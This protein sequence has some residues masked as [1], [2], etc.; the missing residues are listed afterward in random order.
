MRGVPEGRNTV[1]HHGSG[2]KMRRPQRASP[3]RGDTRR[4]GTRDWP[5]TECATLE[6]YA[7]RSLC[8]PSGACLRW[9]SR[10][11]TTSVV[12]YDLPSLRDSWQRISV[13]PSAVT[14]LLAAA[15]GKR[16]RGGAGVAESWSDPSWRVLI[17][18]GHRKFF[19]CL[20]PADTRGQV[21]CAARVELP[22]MRQGDRAV[23]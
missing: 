8:R 9:S 23:R 1:A 2:G 16:C 7:R 15:C 6:S 21:H 14:C 18:P 3:G 22:E 19:E 12:R 17:W 5:I 10:S 4:S 13:P 11:P 20:H